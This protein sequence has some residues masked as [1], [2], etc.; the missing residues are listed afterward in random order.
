MKKE[1]NIAQTGGNWSTNIGNAFINLGSIQAL[2]E[3]NPNSRI[4]LFSSF[5]R[6]LFRT[7][8]KGPVGFLL[9]KNGDIKPV[10]DLVGSAKI[11]YLVS[12]GAILTARQNPM[13]KS[14]SQ[15]LRSKGVKRIINGGGPQE[16]QYEEKKIEEIRDSLAQMKLYA[17]ISRD[18]RSFKYFHDL[19]E[20]SYNGIDCGFFVSD[21][22]TPFQL[23]Y[24]EFVIF[25]FDS[26]TEP[27]IKVDKEIIRTHHASVSIKLIRKY[28]TERKKYFGSSNTLISDI[29][30][31]YLTLYANT[32]ATYS[33][34]V[35][36]CVA[37]LAYGNPA[38]LYS[39]TPRS[40]L[41]DR[42]GLPDIRDMVVYPDLKR[43][44]KEKEKQVEFLSSIL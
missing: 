6:W 2:K 5:S 9:R 11:D 15:K 44:K 41:F 12:S 25:N 18:E 21:Y 36:A 31:D 19:A 1:I 23:E 29:P 17:F 28:L 35:H 7:V 39:T 20:H 38:Q 33:D 37:T 40:L 27:K 26:I 3:A 34:R 10:F 8:N 43:L 13:S 14:L 4:Q 32:K 16:G 42:V 30:E 24:P 22:F